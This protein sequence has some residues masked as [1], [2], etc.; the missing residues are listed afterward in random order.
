MRIRPG[1]FLGAS[2]AP[3][4][5]FRRVSRVWTGVAAGRIISGAR[6]IWLDGHE[7]RRDGVRP[8]TAT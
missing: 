1:V 3:P 5:H 2:R 8:Q 6:G 7:P 4:V